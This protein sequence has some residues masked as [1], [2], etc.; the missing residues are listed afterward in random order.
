MFI[1]IINLV[2]LLENTEFKWGN[3]QIIFEFLG[4]FS[5]LKINIQWQFL[6]KCITQCNF[7]GQE[8]QGQ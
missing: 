7:Q 2:T 5:S 3:S 6:N 8:Y 1:C 4:N